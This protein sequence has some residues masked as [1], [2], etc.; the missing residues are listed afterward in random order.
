MKK[1]LDPVHKENEGKV[2]K[3][4]LQAIYKETGY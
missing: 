1:A 2:G 4:L 3:D